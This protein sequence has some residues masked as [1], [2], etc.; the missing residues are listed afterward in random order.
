MGPEFAKETPMPWTRSATFA[1][2]TVFSPS[3]R[4]S[5]RVLRDAARLGAVLT[6]LVILGYCLSTAWAV[7]G[8]LATVK[9]S[10]CR[11]A[12]DVV[13][14]RDALLCFLGYRVGLELLR[15][16]TRRVAE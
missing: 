5:V 16:A 7:L 10:D 14:V 15:A 6:F 4:P 8:Q 11:R 9:V 2:D 1:W 3:A 12:L 13:S